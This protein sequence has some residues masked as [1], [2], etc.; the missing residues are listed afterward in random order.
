MILGRRNFK[1]I[2]EIKKYFVNHGHCTKEEF[3]EA[4]KK[5]KEIKRDLL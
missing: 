2:E 4:L 3:D 1:N 5:L